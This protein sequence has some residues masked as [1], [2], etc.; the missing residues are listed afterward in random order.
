MA[1]SGSIDFQTTRDELIKDA[2]KKINVLGT[3]ESLASEDLNLAARQLNR[4]VK[5]WQMD[6]VYVWTQQ[7]ATV[8][9]QDS[10]QSYD[11]GVSGDQA[12][13]S[14]VNSTLSAA[15]ASG[16]TVLS[17]TSTTGMTAGDNIGI[18]LDDDTRQWTTIV[19]V[20]SA[21][22]LTVTAALTGAAASGNTV[23]T[24]TTG[25]NRPLRIMSARRQ[26]ENG[27]EKPMIVISRQEYFDL[28]NK[29]DSS[30]V[31][32]VYYDAD[33]RDTGTLYVWPTSDN[34]KDKIR[35]TYTRTIEDFD[36]TSDNP[37]FPVE[38]YDALVYN[39][40]M[41]LAP[42]FRVRSA[43]IQDVQSMAMYLYRQVKAFA[44]ENAPV[45]MQI[46]F[47]MY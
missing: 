24:Y 38:W 19:S 16:Q 7:E 6:G 20:D 35:I 10:K 27:T 31:S 39:L 43:D 23:Y 46:D 15:E 12:S 2:L 42:D 14:V 44:Q 47:D 30:D 32:Y 29:G 11:L 5:S 18:E 36:S 22:E 3:H 34:V 13:N 1:T 25:M 26:D 21:T 9:L 17:I 37:D 4:M 28:V 45:I 8:F 40:A 41:R 33:R